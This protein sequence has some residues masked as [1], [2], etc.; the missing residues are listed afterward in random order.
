VLSELGKVATAALA[1]AVEAQPDKALAFLAALLEL[2]PV[3]PW[4]TPRPGRLRIVAPGDAAGASYHSGTAQRSFSEAFDE[5]AAMKAVDLKK[6]IARMVASAVD[7]SQEWLS[8]NADMRKATL[9]TFGVDPTPQFNVDA[10]FT[11]ARKPVIA[12]A[13][14]EITGQELK[15]GKKGD[16]VAITVDAAKKVG[17]LP[18]YLR[19]AAYK[20]KK[21]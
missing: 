19:T 2:G 12:A 16:M 13:Y 6:A 21:K 5:Y 10:F 17:W 15:D 4:S 9:E 18:E 8:S 3:T 20:P 11:A 7:V 1:E 14:L